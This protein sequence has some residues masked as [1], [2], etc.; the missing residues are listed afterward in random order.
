V[1]IRD[2]TFNLHPRVLTLWKMLSLRL[3][4]RQRL[5]LGVGVIRDDIRG[6]RLLERGEED[7]IGPDLKFSVLK[8]ELAA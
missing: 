1:D 8:N 6:A 3:R 5:L 2:A 4:L 7:L